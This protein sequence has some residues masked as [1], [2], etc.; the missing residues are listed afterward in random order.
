[1]G[2]LRVSNT[3]QTGRKRRDTPLTPINGEFALDSGRRDA[4]FLD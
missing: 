2:K 4:I 1:M 3:L